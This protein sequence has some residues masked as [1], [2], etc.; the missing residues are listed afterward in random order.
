MSARRRLLRWGS[1]FAVLNAGLLAVVGL[2]YLWHYSALQPRIAW[3]YA[4]PAFLGQM[5]ALG[6]IPFLLLVPV[7]LLVPRPRAVVP[8][9]VFLA[10]AVLSFMVLDGL[11]FA[12]T[13]GVIALNTSVRASSRRARSG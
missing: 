2:R 6:Y 12:D 1:W 4:V 9:G 11:V 8:L 13:E 7:M 3:I 5:T 10:S